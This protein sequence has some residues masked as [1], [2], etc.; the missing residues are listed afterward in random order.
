MCLM[1][2]GVTHIAL[3][4]FP[5]VSCV[6]ILIPGRGGWGRNKTIA[7]PVGELRGNPKRYPG[8]DQKVRDHEE[9]QD[10]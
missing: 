1:M 10:V 8:A 7:I 5:I 2:H 3:G 9:K 6:G 4:G